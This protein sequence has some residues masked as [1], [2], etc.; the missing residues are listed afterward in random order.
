MNCKAIF[1][2]IAVLLIPSMYF[3]AH[4]E[5]N[6][7]KV[8]QGKVGER[9]GTGLHTDCAQ[10]T[11]WAALSFRNSDTKPSTAGFLKSLVSTLPPENRA[12]ASMTS[13]EQGANW[14][15]AITNR[16]PPR[17]CR[18]KP[19]RPCNSSLRHWFASHC[20]LRAS[21]RGQSRKPDTKSQQQVGG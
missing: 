5:K 7:K 3:Y 11:A 4:S 14:M 1:H 8:L 2:K 18:L 10:T 16:C 20:W 13:F 9:C 17:S 21:S 12:L 6:T 19:D 15:R